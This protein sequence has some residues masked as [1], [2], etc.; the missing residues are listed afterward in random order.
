MARTPRKAAGVTDLGSLERIEAMRE[1]ARKMILDLLWAD[2][3]RMT[4]WALTRAC[5]YLDHPVNPGRDSFGKCRCG[6]RRPAQ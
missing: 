1:E 2:Y 4:P 3:N 6:R 5:E